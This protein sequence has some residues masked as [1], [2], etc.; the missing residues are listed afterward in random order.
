[1]NSNGMLQVEINATDTLMLIHCCGLK[2]SL[3]FLMLVFFVT[4]ELQVT[5]VLY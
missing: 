5:V 2:Y 3:R 1:M 4:F